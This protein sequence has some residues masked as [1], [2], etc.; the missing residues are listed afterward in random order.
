MARP[1]RLGS[2][3][4][5]AGALRGGADPA[6]E[7]AADGIEGIV[8]GAAVMA[9]SHLPRAGGVAIAV[10]VT[11][12]TY[13]VAERY[14]RLV[15]ERIR[16]GQRPG[17]RHVRA[18]LTRGWRFVTASVLP[19][20][21]LLLVGRLGGEVDRAVLAGLASSTALLVLAGWEVGR[22]GRLGTLD[23]VVAAAAAGSFGLAMIFLNALIH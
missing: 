9:A 20:A 22:D 23:R 10:L 19:V 15:A 5:V 6:A 13:W 1:P 14:A 8:V 7:D 18:Q 17:W 16:D 2:V 4:A 21:V 11:L 3:G 12:L